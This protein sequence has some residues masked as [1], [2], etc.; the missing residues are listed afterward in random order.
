MSR[1][2][3]ILVLAHGHDHGASAVA[4]T[5]AARRGADAVLRLSPSDLTRAGW[6][7]T[8]SPRGRVDGA[9]QPPSGHR[10]APG[11][12]AC[13]L[14]RLT[15]IRPPAFARADDRERDYAAAEMQ[16]LVLSWLTGLRCPVIHAPGAAGALS[17]RQWFARAIRAGIPVGHEVA[18]TSARLVPGQNVTPPAVGRPVEV[19]DRRDGPE[20]MVLVAGDRIH[21]D[22]DDALAGPCLALAAATGCGLLS[23]T[24]AGG[25]RLV[26]V[27]PFPPLADERS[28]DAAA[29]LVERLSR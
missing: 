22:L 18:A 12:V 15:A 21:G 6:T 2:L 1:E 13:V 23:L 19:R 4:R 9:V 16:A 17:R 3:V 26:D 5:I 24:F 25:S 27:D 29:S 10:L 11:G 7:H 28:I 20:R 14:D 8:I